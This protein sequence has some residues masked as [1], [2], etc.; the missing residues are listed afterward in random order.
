MEQTNGLLTTKAAALEVAATGP[1]S[2]RLKLE[3]Q[4]NVVRKQLQEAS[5]ELEAMRKSEHSQNLALLEELNVM[6]SENTKLRDQLRAR[7]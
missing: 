6:Q 4:L 2:T 3:A 7:K 1:E 5:E